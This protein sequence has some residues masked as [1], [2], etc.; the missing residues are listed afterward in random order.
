[1]PYR[2][3]DNTEFGLSLSTIKSR[4]P[5]TSIPASPSESDLNSLGYATYEP[6]ERPATNALTRAVEIAPFQLTGQRWVQRWVLQDL[7]PDAASQADFLL[8]AKLALCN[9]VSEKR[10]QV[11]TGGITIGGFPIRTDETSQAKIS[12]AVNL[13][14]YDPE[15]THIDWEGEPGV[16]SAIDK[17]TMILIGVSVG[18]HVQACFSKAKALKEQIMAIVTG[19]QIGRAHV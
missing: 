5:N 2:K 4:F 1:M 13:M 11:E 16:F 18:R 14:A 8:Q 19:K 6:T 9:S 17:N 7:Y 15:M 12:G 10:Y 3:L